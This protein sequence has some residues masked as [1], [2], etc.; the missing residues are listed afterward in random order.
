MI[1]FFHNELP[2]GERLFQ[3]QSNAKNI[4]FLYLISQA[5]LETYCL[6]VIEWKLE[7]GMMV[8]C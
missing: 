2:L 8:T 3:L 4:Y 7:F 1:F 6:P 5:S